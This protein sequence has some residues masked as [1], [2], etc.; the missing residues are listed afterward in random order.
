MNN[1]FFSDLL[2]SI[3]ERGRTLLRRAGS[4][5]GKQDTSDLVEL[6]EALLSGR[7]EASGTAMAR[8]VLDRYHHLDDASRRSFFETLVRNYGPDRQRIAQA[9]ETWRAQP[10][11]E[12][13]SDLHFASEPDRKST[14]LNSSH[15]SISYAV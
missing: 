6:C 8:E 12:D 2:A 14:R 15:S 13:A 1:A 5:N 4:S 7:G 3:S 10:T 11:D 9:I